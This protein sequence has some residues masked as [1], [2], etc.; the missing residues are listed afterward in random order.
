VARYSLAG[1]STCGLTQPTDVLGVSP[2][3]GALAANSGPTKTFPPN[4]G[5]SVIGTGDPTCTGT[6]QRGVDRPQ[7]GAC[8]RGAVGQ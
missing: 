1:D 7:G 8:D 5:S 6:D 2:N 3:L 4:A